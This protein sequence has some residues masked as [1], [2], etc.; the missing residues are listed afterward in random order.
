LGQLD[1]VL[2]SLSQAYESPAAIVVTACLGLILLIFLLLLVA[3]RRRRR[4]LV[5]AIN[6][7]EGLKVDNLREQ[8][9]QQIERWLPAGVLREQWHEFA[10]GFVALNGRYYNTLAA[11]AFIKDEMVLQDTRIW[12]LRVPMLRILPSIATG[13]GVLGTFLGVAFGLGQI[14]LDSPDKPAAVV[15]SGAKKA[16][17]SGASKRLV[18]TPASKHRAT[19]TEFNASLQRVIQGLAAAF[20]T[21]IFGVL[22]ALIINLFGTMKEAALVAT[23]DKLRE[24]LD[25]RI[26]RLTPDKLLDPL[27]ARLATQGELLESANTLHTTHGELLTRSNKLSGE[28]AETLNDLAV[29]AEENRDL[30]QAMANDIADGVGKQFSTALNDVLAPQLQAITELVRGQ[31]EQASASS[32][33]QARRFTDEMVQQVTGALQDGITQ[34]GSQVKA[35]SEQMAT[36]STTLSTVVERAQSSVE[37]SYGALDRGREAIEASQAQSAIAAQQF[38]AFTTASAALEGVVQTLGGSQRE[39]QATQASQRELQQRTDAQMATVAERFTTISTDVEAS[40]AKLAEATQA[41]AVGAER[42]GVRVEGMSRSTEAAG[43]M[44]D[45]AAQRLETRIDSES[46]LL[47]SYGD[48]QNRFEVAFQQARPALDAMVSATT[49]IREVLGTM[50]AERERI[51]DLLEQIQRTHA[52]LR[53]LST[54]LTS[55][56][57]RVEQALREAAT[58]AGTVVSNTQDWADRAT[59]AIERFGEQMSSSLASSLQ[60]YDASLAGAVKNL[61]GAMKELEDL[62]EEIAEHRAQ[63]RGN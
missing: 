33:E 23:V 55:G 41:L 25:R 40:V 31:V 58:D 28:Q 36:V 14:K 1:H 34:M 5:D 52:E 7:I 51:N 32:V 16:S 6:K 27:L 3:A 10:E 50:P 61:S 2:K 53:D 4:S 56:Y 54:V 22:L 13:L 35:A 9:L 15:T 39:L 37:S 48:A 17:P 42:I 47:D 57:T 8:D 24:A 45:S 43:T 30:L 29:T 18:Q 59:N 44:I 11:D 21:S 49:V 62:A 20:W 38:E 12:R 46:R 60:Q 26:Q 63:R 19:K